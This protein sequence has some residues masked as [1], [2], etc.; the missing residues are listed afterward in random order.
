MEHTR[1]FTLE[2]RYHKELGVFVLGLL[3]LGAGLDTFVREL[4]I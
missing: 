3:C 2:M 1:I 4:E